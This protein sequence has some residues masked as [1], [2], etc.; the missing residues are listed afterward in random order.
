MYNGS[1]DVSLIQNVTWVSPASGPQDH[2]GDE[3]MVAF[4]CKDHRA[5]SDGACL[6]IVK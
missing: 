2:P 4:S 1:A 5:Q 6:S 3:S